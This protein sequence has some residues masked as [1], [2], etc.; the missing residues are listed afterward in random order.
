MANGWIC[1]RCAASNEESAVACQTCGLGRDAQVPAAPSADATTPVDAP[2]PMPPAAFDPAATPA[3]P[4]PA[5]ASGAPGGW[6]GAPQP[7]IQPQGAG[8]QVAKG[9]L[10]NVGARVLVIGVIVVVGLVVG[11]FVNA[12]RD[13]NGNINKAG[14]LNI[15]ELH[16]GDCYDIPGEDASP[17]PSQAVG[18]THA[19]PCTE[20]HHYEVFYVGS[21]PGTTYPSDAELQ[22]WAES[23]C[24]PAFQAY[25]G[26]PY[27]QSSLDV[28]WFYPERAGWAK[29]DRGGQ[30]S[31]ADT[32][33]KTFKQSLKGSGY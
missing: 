26:T 9:I 12:G 7:S 32:N 5:S 3:P 19:T 24:V 15:T 33:K 23:A 28:A 13:S 14:D 20:P 6:P 31:L 1:G 29:G 2:P 18:T 4:M 16:V 21:I 27:D 8:K 10:A 25:V 30:C 17:D 11:F 22:K